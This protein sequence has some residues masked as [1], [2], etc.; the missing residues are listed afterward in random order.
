MGHPC[1]CPELS[2]SRPLGRAHKA[3]L[4]R[5]YEWCRSRPRTTQL[6][7]Q[8]SLAS[9]LECVRLLILLLIFSSLDD[10]GRRTGYIQQQA[11]RE[12]NKT[13]GFSPAINQ[14]Q[15]RA[16]E[17]EMTPFYCYF[18]LESWDSLRQEDGRMDGW[19][20]THRHRRWDDAKEE[21][22]RGIVCVCVWCFFSCFF[23][24]AKTGVF[25][26]LLLSLFA[27]L[28]LAP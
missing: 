2:R 8:R 6:Q 14:G 1:P 13:R 24:L 4:L 23:F 22:E 12:K 16:E 28:S 11:T 15:G 21:R 27:S 10:D 26:L 20:A 25:L 3:E 7:H 5:V 19:I 9:Q 17:G 18:T